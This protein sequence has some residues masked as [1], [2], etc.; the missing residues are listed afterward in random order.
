M[1]AGVHTPIAT[2]IDPAG[3]TAQLGVN[4]YF[5]AIEAFSR[6]RSMKTHSSLSKKTQIVQDYRSW[7]M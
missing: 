4:S 5:D 6:L 3:S 2:C 7:I 1:G